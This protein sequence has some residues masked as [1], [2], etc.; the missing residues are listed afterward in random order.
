MIKMGIECHNLEQPR[1]GV[2]HYITSF[3]QEVA[4]KNPSDFK[5]YLYFHKKIP[6]FEV[7]KNPIFEKKIIKPLF[8]K[9]SMNIFYH[10][11]MP[12]TARKDKIDIMFL[13][14]YLMPIFYLLPFAKRFLKFKT[15]VTLH[16]ISYTAHPEWFRKIRLINYRIST[17]VAVKKA[18]LILTISEFSK[19]EIIKYYN[20]NPNKIAVNYLA[21]RDVF[22]KSE[23]IDESY[24]DLIKNKYGI[25]DKF[26]L[27]VGQ[28]TLRRRVRELIMAFKNIGKEFPGYQLF[29]VGFD[30]SYPFYDLDKLIRQTNDYLSR[31]AVQRIDYIEQDSDILALYK[32]ASLFV[33]I[34]SYEGFGLPPIEA[35]SCGTPIVI[36]ANELSKE[37]LN[38]K[39]FLVK[40]ETDPIDIAKTIKKAL[41]NKNQAMDLVSQGQ[42]ELKKFSWEK[43]TEKLLRLFQSINNSGNLKK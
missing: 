10:I 16:D 34:S 12:L 4:K 11:L 26:I 36:K 17:F 3:L 22:L 18:D 32:K 6:D 40:D 5:F 41:E 30:R 14:S 38:D 9:P 33:Y 8:G 27:F 19:K 13:P 31:Q 29:I 1:W 21:I 39:A 20:I 35:L 24:L 23:K 42:E 43:H 15:I 37:L 28:A 2:G 7:L 25:K